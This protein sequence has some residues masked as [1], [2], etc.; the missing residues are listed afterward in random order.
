MPQPNSEHTFGDRL[1]RG[2]EMQGEIAAFTPAFA[3][4]DTSLTAANYDLFLGTVEA[5]N[6][7]VA[8][9]EAAESASITL[10][11]TL[12]DLIK[13]RTLRVVDTVEGNEA[14][15]QYLPKIKEHA[16]MVRNSRPPKPPPAAPSGP[17]K[18]KRKT[19]QQSYGDIDRWFD[20]L[21][22]AVKLVPGYNP[23]ASSNTQITQLET[24][25]SDYRTANKDEA[26]NSAAASKQR[27]ER[28][29]LYN[30]KTGSLRSKMKAI[31]KATGGQYTRKSTQYAA[32][33]SIA[34]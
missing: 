21:I 16:A 4:D 18:P 14:W 30:A 3:P 31:K 20:K 33:K 24:L 13:A 25:L 2:R 11:K 23:A 8:T 12:Y 10:H 34:L 6:T 7:L 1:A 5:K 29:V 9:A 26:T 32:V 15:Q 28:L 22:E 19:G 17:V 27:D